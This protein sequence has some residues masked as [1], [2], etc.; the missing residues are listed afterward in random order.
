MPSPKGSSENKQ[1]SGYRSSRCS[2]KKATNE[3]SL[4]HGPMGPLQCYTQHAID[5]KE[6]Y[7]RAGT[8]SSL[9]LRFKKTFESFGYLLVKK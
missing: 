3:S 5:A 4:I 1:V 2:D 9:F 6:S 8:M 7:R